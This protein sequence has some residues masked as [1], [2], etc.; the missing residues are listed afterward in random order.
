MR[1]VY[2]IGNGFDINLGLPTKYHDFYKHYLGLDQSADTSTVAEMKNHIRKCLSGKNDYWSDLEAA[3]GAYTTNFGDYATLEASYDDLNDSLH[4]YISQVEAAP[5]P[6]GIDVSLFK[7]NLRAPEKF[8][9]LAER[10]TIENEVYKFNIGTHFIDIL[11]FNYTTTIEKLLKMPA[12]TIE[13][14]PATYH[15]SYPT[16]LSPILH[17]HGDTTQPIL[18]INDSSQIANDKLREDLDVLDYLVK[19]RMNSNA[20]HLIDRHAREAIKNANMICI[21]GL[22][23]GKTDTI[24]WK[25]VGERLLAGK[26]VVLFVHDNSGAPVHPRKLGSYK[27]KW[28][29]RFFTATSLPLEKLTQLSSNLIIAPNTPIF[30]LRSRPS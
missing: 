24:W 11:N 20:G 19:P 2:M 25:L 18:G 17:I 8:L 5:L 26:N 30:N 6:A 3:M 4:A 15:S 9:T 27:R 22:S 10:E 7:R 12:D 13:I 1:T 29:E 28:A 21:Y 16:K 14:G 23:L